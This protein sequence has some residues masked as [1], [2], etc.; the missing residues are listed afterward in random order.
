MK[1]I[2][3]VEDDLSLI[4]GLSFALRQQGYEIVNARTCLEAETLWQDDSY[5]LVILDV[6]LP[7]GSGYDLCRLIRQSSKVPILFLTAADEETDV[8]MGLDIGGD[9][10]ITKPFKLAIFLSRVNALLRRSGDFRQPDDT[11]QSGGITVHQLTR[12][13]IKDGTPVE[14]TASEY[15]LLCFFLEHS[16]LVLSPEQILGKLWDCEQNYIDSSTLTVYIRRLRAKIE[17]DPS[18]PKRIITVRRMGY[19]WNAEK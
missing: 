12:E 7:D 3:F 14:L 17:D 2:F 16:N 5:D 6:T 1:R 9:D 10:Y 8:I 19:K 13:V 11:L 4:H 15:K 18:S